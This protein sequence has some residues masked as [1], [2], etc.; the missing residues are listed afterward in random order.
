MAVFYFLKQKRE[1][2]VIFCVAGPERKLR[3]RDMGRHA[4]G[5]TTTLCPAAAPTLQFALPCRAEP[6]S[7][8]DSTFREERH[9]FWATKTY[10]GAEC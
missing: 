10:K 2:S 5:R 6:H 7:K 3:G 8:Q 4:R 9:C 1:R